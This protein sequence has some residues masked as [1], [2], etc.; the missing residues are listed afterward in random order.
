M[1][2]RNL[3][4]YKNPVWPLNPLLTG[5]SNLPVKWARWWAHGQ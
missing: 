1:S 3:I 2:F 4:S 5:P